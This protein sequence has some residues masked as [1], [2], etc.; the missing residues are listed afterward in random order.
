MTPSDGRL[1]A[2]TNSS[3]LFDTHDTVLTASWTPGDGIVVTSSE[4]PEPWHRAL[5][6][7]GRDLRV[8]H[9]N[10][11]IAH[12]GFEAAHD[13][14]MDSVWLTSNVTPLGGVPAGL[15]HSGGGAPVYG[16][17]ETIVV[18]CAD[19]DQDQIPRTGIMWPRGHAGGFLSASVLDGIASWIGRD[20]E[21][22]VIGSLPAM[23]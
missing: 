1:C 20:G 23:T 17:E 14:A 7:L 8:R 5:G 6:R 16:D 13:R 2:V 19:L 10:G 11:A 12:I 18:S 3:R 9:F 22:E 21:R 4:L 15:G